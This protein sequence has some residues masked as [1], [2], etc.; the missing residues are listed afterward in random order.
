MMSVE[1]WVVLAIGAAF[2]QTARNAI[3]QSV[4]AQI[5]PA[6]N[7]W[8]RFA[9][10][11]PFA[12]LACALVVASKGMPQLPPR[13]FAYCL[14][15]AITQ[16]LGNVALIAAFRSGGFGEA[17]VFHKLEVL[18]AAMAG[19]LLFS[20]YPSAV[21]GIGILICGVGALWINLGRESNGTSWYRIFAFGRAGGLALLCASLLVLA[22]FALKAANSVVSSANVGIAEGGFGAPVQTLFH[23]TWIEVVLLTVWIGVREPASFGHVS[24]HWRRMAL[25]GSASFTASICWFWAYSL[26]LVAYVKAVGQIE[27]LLAVAL[28]IRLLGERN[29]IRQLPGILLVTAGIVLVLLG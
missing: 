12:A 24:L 26:T 6:L 5:S 2:A 4:S 14:A 16:L 10:C 29:L 11:L 17:I 1:L 20:E 13:F 23:T 22:S 19:A 18:I 3:A 27:A 7:S 15:T 8:S 9:F 25:I 21:G 28:G